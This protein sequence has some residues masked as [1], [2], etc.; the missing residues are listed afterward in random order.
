MAGWGLPYKADIA[1]NAD[2]IAEIGDLILCC[3]SKKDETDAK[4]MA[5]SPG[6][7]NMLSWATETLIQDGRSQSDISA[8]GN[9]GSNGRGHQHGPA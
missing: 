6:F 3:N 4:G 1:I 2:T 9:A 5:V 7:I 8:G